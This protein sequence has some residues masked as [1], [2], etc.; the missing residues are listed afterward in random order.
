MLVEDGHVVFQCV[1]T[2]AARSFTVLP[3]IEQEN[4]ITALEKFQSSIDPESICLC[5]I[6]ESEHSVW[7]DRNSSALGYLECYHFSS[8]NI[9]FD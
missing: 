8:S 7:A 9:K 2:F 1:V 4:S 3:I 5:S 6:E